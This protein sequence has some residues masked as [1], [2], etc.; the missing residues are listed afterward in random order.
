MLP[1]VFTK[2]YH[3]KKRDQSNYQIKIKGILVSW[4]WGFKDHL[5][6]QCLIVSNQRTRWFQKFFLLYNFTYHCLHTLKVR[7]FAIIFI[8][9]LRKSQEVSNS[10]SLVT[11]LAKTNVLLSRVLSTE[12]SILWILYP[13][14]QIFY[15]ISNN[16]VKKLYMLRWINIF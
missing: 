7:R 4:F 15:I 13:I 1:N 11:K 8:F 5:L 6:E 2:L 14:W 16:R 3:Q 9:R 12:P 10:A